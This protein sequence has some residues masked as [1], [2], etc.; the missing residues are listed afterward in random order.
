MQA[1]S[2][3]IGVSR[4]GSFRSLRRCAMKR[5]GR[6]MAIVTDRLRFYGAS[7]HN[8][9]N[10]ERHLTRRADFKEDRS[11]AL[12]EWR[13]E[14]CR[15]DQLCISHNLGHKFRLAITLKIEERRK[16]GAI[17]ANPCGFS[18]GLPGMKG[19]AQACGL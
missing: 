19:D 16:V 9:F 1:L 5:Y 4:K 8:H 12:S 2:E 11:A 13:T 14:E 15:G 7:I 10:L 6:P 18:H 17:N 3:Q